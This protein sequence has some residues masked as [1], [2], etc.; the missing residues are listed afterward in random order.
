[1][2]KLAC[3]AG[4]ALIASTG[5]AE[6]FTFVGEDNDFWTDEDAW[7]DEDNDPG[8]P[9]AGDRAVIDPGSAKTVIIRGMDSITVETVEVGDLG[10]ILIEADGDDN[11]TLT[12]TNHVCGLVPT[13]ASFNS[14][15]DGVIELESEATLAIETGNHTISGDGAILAPVDNTATSG[16]GQITIA[17]GKFFKNGKTDAHTGIRGALTISG[18][19]RFINDGLVEAVQDDTGDAGDVDYVIIDVG[20]ME[21]T[22]DASWVTNC[23]AQMVFRSGGCLE[24]DFDDVGVTNGNG[25]SFLF[26]GATVHTKGVY[27]RLGCGEIAYA[28]SGEFAFQALVEG[29]D[30]VDLSTSNIFSGQCFG[31]PQLLKAAAISQGIDCAGSP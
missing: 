28:D 21:D 30:C 7:E 10:T 29:D 8:V 1:M 3:I 25:G 4:A 14:I 12:L 16:G 22:S 18:A 2:K 9:G 5:F 15:L 27:T 6:T 24:G 11:G 20:I 26:D 19:G 17:S 13:C 31:Y 23:M